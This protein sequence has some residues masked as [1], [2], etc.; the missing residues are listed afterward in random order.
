MR[1]PSSGNADVPPETRKAV[2]RWLDE[3]Q[4]E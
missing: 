3:A 1:W 2:E 4:R